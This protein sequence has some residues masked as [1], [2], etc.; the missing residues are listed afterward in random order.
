LSIDPIDNKINI[1]YINA[2]HTEIIQ[3]E[4]TTYYYI[5][6]EIESDIIQPDNLN[7]WDIFTAEYQ[8]SNQ[9]INFYYKT[10]QDYIEFTPPY[11]FSEINSSLQ[12]KIRLNSDNSST[13]VITSLSINYIESI[14]CQANFTCTD[15]TECTDETQ[16]RICTDINQCGS[17]DY[18]ETQNCTIEENEEQ[19]APQSSSS[20]P[21][22]LTRYSSSSPSPA[23]SVPAVQASPVVET[24]TVSQP[25]ILKAEPEEQEIIVATKPNTFKIIGN[26]LGL[27]CISLLCFL[28]YKRRRKN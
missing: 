13:P 12:F 16:T 4:N 2:S 27:S 19:T 26:A 3:H 24:K 17:E 25:V 8:S 23:Q 7:K 22:S 14:P 5:P 1:D 9:T 11:N 6:D 18:I 20:Q 21:P 15:W 10:N 28:V